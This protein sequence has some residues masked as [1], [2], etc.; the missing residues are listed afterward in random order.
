MNIC[1][2][3]PNTSREMTRHIEAE[4]LK[5]KNGDTKLDVV[6]PAHGPDT[7]ECAVDE[8]HAVPEMLKLVQGAERDGADAVVI[9]CFSDPGL[10]AAREAASIPVL[11]MGEAGIHAAAMLGARFTVITPVRRRIPTRIHQALHLVSSHRL[12]SVRSLDISVARSESDPEGTVKA[13]VRVAGEAVR[14]D[15]AEVIVLGCAGMAGCTETLEREY[16][17]VVVD[18]CAAALKFAEIFVRLGLRQSKLG[19]YAVPPKKIYR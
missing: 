3:N 4:L 15:G 14:E 9:A 2:V 16:G 8:A 10:D 6:C 12:A 5:V 18:P 7:L 19:H 17:V 13:L 1:V 11:G